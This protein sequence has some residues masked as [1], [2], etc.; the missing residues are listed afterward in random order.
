MHILKYFGLG[1]IRMQQIFILIHTYEMQRRTEKMFN[2]STLTVTV[3]H[4]F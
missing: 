2:K 3:K 4:L 1:Y